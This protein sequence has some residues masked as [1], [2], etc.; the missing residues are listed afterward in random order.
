M[1][2]FDGRYVVRLFSVEQFLVHVGAEESLNF[3]V[4]EHHVVAES[5]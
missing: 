4:E 3:S 2:V 5:S 1:D